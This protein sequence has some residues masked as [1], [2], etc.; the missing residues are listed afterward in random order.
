MAM[1]LHLASN[2]CN[3]GDAP[4]EPSWRPLVEPTK[5][6]PPTLPPVGVFSANQ[7]GVQSTSGASAAG[8]IAHC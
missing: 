8:P 5:Q 4:L 3:A 7:S 6:R 2:C 1:T